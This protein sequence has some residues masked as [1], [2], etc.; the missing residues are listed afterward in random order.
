MFFYRGIIALSAFLLLSVNALKSP[1][2]I[3]GVV[4]TQSKTD[5]LSYK[6]PTNV[7][8]LEYNILLDPSLSGGTFH[9]ECNIKVNV[10]EATKTITFHAAEIKFLE[11]IVIDAENFKNYPLVARDDE[12]KQFRILEFEN[13]LPVGKYDLW[14]SYSGVLRDDGYGFY[15]SS[16]RNSDGETRLVLLIINNY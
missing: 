3:D 7:I 15:K 9:G 2:R 13:E 10:I 5:S 4:S 8:P 11:T 6:L 1:P 12:E 16:Y 14:I